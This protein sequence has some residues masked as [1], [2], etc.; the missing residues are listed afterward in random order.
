MGAGAA[1]QVTPRNWVTPEI[2]SSSAPASARCSG[3]HG[4]VEWG[5]APA[6]A[7][8]NKKRATSTKVGRACAWACATRLGAAFGLE[9][10][11]SA[12]LI[13]GHGRSGAGSFH[14][15]DLI[16]PTSQPQRADVVHQIVSLHPGLGQ[17]RVFVQFPGV[18]HVKHRN[19]FNEHEMV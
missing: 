18:H 14:P 15:C 8:A 9:L 13:V 2:A 5:T 4:P 10:P 17:R 6:T 16:V 12:K 19:V 7:A 1:P 3:N 11:A